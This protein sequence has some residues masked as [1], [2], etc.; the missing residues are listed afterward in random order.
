MATLSDEELSGRA[1][2]DLH[3]LVDTVAVDWDGEAKVYHLE[4]RDKL[5]AMLNAPRPAGEAGL[6]ECE[7]SVNLVAGVGFEPTTFRL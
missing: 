7:S 4:L 3:T 1:S 2:E 6:G 5:L